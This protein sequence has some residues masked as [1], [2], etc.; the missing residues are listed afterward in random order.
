MKRKAAMLLAGAMLV[1]GILT[2]C[3]SKGGAGE[4]KSADPA[5]AAEESQAKEETG[6]E[7][8]ESAGALEGDITF[9]HSFTQGPRLEVIQATADQFMKDNPGVTITIETFS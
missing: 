9:W 4:T 2:G 5:P 6:E 8:E 1:S 3:G 7:V